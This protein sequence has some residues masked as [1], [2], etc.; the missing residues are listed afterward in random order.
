MD[1]AGVTA[2]GNCDYRFTANSNGVY[3]WRIGKGG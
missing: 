1:G 2:V 3:A